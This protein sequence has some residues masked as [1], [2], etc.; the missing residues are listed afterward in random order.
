MPII[1]AGFF[2]L[3]KLDDNQTPES[4]QQFSVLSKTD[5]YFKYVCKDILNFELNNRK[6]L[7]SQ[8]IYFVRP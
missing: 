1:C 3:I 5:S 4:V 2:C 8:Q 7:F 6:S